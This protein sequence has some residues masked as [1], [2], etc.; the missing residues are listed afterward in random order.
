MR[1]YTDIYGVTVGWSNTTS[2]QGFGGGSHGGDASVKSKLIN[3]MT[4][5]RTLMRSK[6]PIRASST[7]LLVCC[8][9]AAGVLA[10]VGVIA[11]KDVDRELGWD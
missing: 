4:S 7:S 8:S 2:D 5:V 9:E 10:A 1:S 11:K 3:L 6:W